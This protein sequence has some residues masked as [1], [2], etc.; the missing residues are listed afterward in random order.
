MKQRNGSQRV[1]AEAL[2]K[3][4]RFFLINTTLLTLS[5]AANPSWYLPVHAAA[6]VTATGDAAQDAQKAQN[7]GAGSLLAMTSTGKPVGQCALKHTSVST[8]ISGYVA[9]VTVKQSFTNPYKDKIEAIYTFPLSDSGAV[10]SMTMQVGNRTIR[11]SIKKREEAKQIYENAK[12]QGHVASLLDQE[13]T[14]IFTQSVAIIAAAHL[15]NESVFS[16]LQKVKSSDCI[17]HKAQFFMLCADPGMLALVTSPSVE[18]AA[19][20][21]GADKYLL[22]PEFDAE[23]LVEELEK[24]FPAVP[25]KEVSA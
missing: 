10:D 11:G 15:E 17:L 22:M 1:R 19:T 25:Y 24:L 13:R 3:L 14:N 5:G 7:G 21:M 2:S 23:K 4:G 9:R 18:I 6:A 20:L 12:A 8:K 16:F